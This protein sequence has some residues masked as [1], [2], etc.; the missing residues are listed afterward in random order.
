MNQ[1]NKNGV[2][3]NIQKYS[4]HD[5][6]GIRTTIFLK[7]C[8][9]RCKWCAN[10]E[11]INPSP[12][13]FLR[14]DKC[15]QCGKCIEVCDLNALILDGETIELDFTKCNSC[16]MCETICI[17]GVISCTGRE[18]SIDE[19]IF[20]AMQDELFYNN[21]GGGITLSG[22]APLFLPECALELL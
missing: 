6:P 19:I 9:L 16:M 4:I 21:S 18:V 3:F 14:K 15:D 20:E 11:S 10:P 22:G 17:N 12:E 1:Q 8:P 13:I 5:G 7:G 2:I